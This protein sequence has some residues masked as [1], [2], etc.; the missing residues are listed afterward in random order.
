MKIAIVSTDGTN[1]NE[2]FGKAEKFLVYD[3][4]DSG[5][6]L[7]E[8]RPS[9]PLSV[10]DPDHPFD[11][12]RFGAIV[13][14]IKDCKSVYIT[15]IGETPATKLKEQGIEPKIFKGPINNIPV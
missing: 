12:D 9:T 4:S 3:A 7:I 11:S 1:V 8:E 2:H 5:L 14:V 10:G 13:D 15:Q 6:K